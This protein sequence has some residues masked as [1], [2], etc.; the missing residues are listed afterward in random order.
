M[1]KQGMQL[2]FYTQAD[3][4][5][6]EIPIYEWLVE[7]AKQHDIAGMTVIG[8]FEGVGHDGQTHLTNWFDLSQQPIRVIMVLS[9]EKSTEFVNML[10]AYQLNVFY[11]LSPMQYGFI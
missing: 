10:S 3:R 8:G 4:S 2:T 5:H 11:T 9:N 6:N 7:Q 1:M